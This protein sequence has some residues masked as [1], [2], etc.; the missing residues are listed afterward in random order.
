MAARP[1]TRLGAHG[2]PA[3]CEL[4]MSS[5]IRRNTCT[6]GSQSF[7]TRRY[8]WHPSDSLSR[9]PAIKP[10]NNRS[11]G[12]RGGKA[13]PVTDFRQ[14]GD[15]MLCR[16]ELLRFFGNVCCSFKNYVVSS[17]CLFLL[18]VLC[19]LLSTAIIAVMAYLSLSVSVLRCLFVQETKAPCPRGMHETALRRKPSVQSPN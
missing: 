15:P 17:R 10:R 13:G 7:M 5:R 2:T 4:Q 1:E 3:S 12:L 14:S 16:S 8:C 9:F 18:F 11:R 6:L 19:F